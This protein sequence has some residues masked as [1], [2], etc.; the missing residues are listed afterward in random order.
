[1]LERSL[2]ITAA[3]WSPSV[4]T[5]G[6]TV[7]PSGVPY[8]RP[9]FRRVSSSLHGPHTDT[10]PPSP[11][12]DWTGPVCFFNKIFQLINHDPGMAPCLSNRTPRLQSSSVLCLT[13]I[14]LR[15]RHCSSPASSLSSLQSC[16]SLISGVQLQAVRRPHTKI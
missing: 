16:A 4:R 12:W 6:G 10:C 13:Q 8:A 1:M 7:R 3:L 9:L 5:H 14:E 15:S 2:I 11:I